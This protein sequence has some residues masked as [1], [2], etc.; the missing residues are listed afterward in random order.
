[1]KKALFVLI[2]FTL[3]SCETS[4]QKDIRLV[5]ETPGWIVKEQNIGDF[6][7]ELAGIT[8]EIEWN[9]VDAASLVKPVI[10]KQVDTANLAMI[11]ARLRKRDSND[12]INELHFQFFVNTNTEVVELGY[13]GFNGEPR[14]PFEEDWFLTFYKMDLNPD[15]DLGIYSILRLPMY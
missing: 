8:G 13:I 15:L 1:M 2:A 10:R 14:G 3:L 12:K 7:G 9:R 6:F 4:L 5:K 11:E